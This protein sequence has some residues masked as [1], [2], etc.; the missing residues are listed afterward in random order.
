MNLEESPFRPGQPVPAE[1]FVGRRN[2]VER[3]RAMVRA[4]NRGNFKLG[5]V[6]GE[7]GIGKSSLASFVRHLAER[8]GNAAGCHV[9]L[10]GVRDLTE[11]VRRT[12]DRLLKESL[13]R[14]W[15]QQVMDF[16]GNHVRKVGLFG[17]SVELALDSRDLDTISRDFVPSMTRLLGTIKNQR[18]SLLLILDD[19]NGIV[20]SDTFAHWLKSTVDEIATSE[21]STPLCMLVVGLEDRRRELV[22]RQPSL[23]RVFEMIDVPQWSEDEVLDFYRRSFESVQARVQKNDLEVLARYSGGFPVL[24]HEIGDAVWRMARSSDIRSDGIVNGVLSAA[25]IIGQKFLEPQVLDAL[26]SERYRSI[27]RKIAG[28][29]QTT[30][31]RRSELTIRLTAEETKVVDNFL[32]RMRRLGVLE[33]DPEVRG[34]YRFTN[35]L[36]AL[37]FRMEAFGS[38]RLPSSD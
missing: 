7:R 9:F 6:S 32:R 4:A 5:F 28:G 3:L 36:H 37:Y 35:L 27:L 38:G 19:I 2:E 8:E 22:R 30:S 16:F 29:M 18:S 11:V 10:G 13:D 34:R 25:A 33:P 20:E 1:F 14:P 17:V 21:R 12:F 24:A 23:A 26:H 15:R 31:F